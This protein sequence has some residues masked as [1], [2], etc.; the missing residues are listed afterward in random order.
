MAAPDRR[1]RAAAALA[2]AA[3]LSGCAHHELGRSA[4]LGGAS[5]KALVRLDDGGE[6]WV[7]REEPLARRR[8]PS[9]PLRHDSSRLAELGFEESG[10]GAAL[11]PGDEVVFARRVRREAGV[12]RKAA[13]GAYYV[14]ALPL[15]VALTVATLGTTALL[16]PDWDPPRWI[17]DDVR[18]FRGTVVEVREAPPAVEAAA[19]APAKLRCSDAAAWYR[20]GDRFY[21]PVTAPAL[22]RADVWAPPGG[23]RREAGG[24]PLA[25][26]AQ[27]EDSALRGGERT[28]LRGTARVTP[29]G[30]DARAVLTGEARA[31]VEEQE[32]VLLEG[33]EKDAPLLALD[34]EA[35]RVGLDVGEA[36]RWRLAYATAPATVV[37]ELVLAAAPEHLRAIEAS[38]PAGWTRE[39]GAD[40]RC[41]VY[42][43][44]LAPDAGLA[45]RG[46][47]ELRGVA[48]LD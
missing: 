44:R 15:T 7:S 43:W 47:V 37:D 42:V 6:A 45:A 27:R 3:L 34:V 14:T 17:E 11:A 5:G 10:P 24:D 4:A 35:S 32:R 23:R 33:G 48:A 29:F 18:A 22:V 41:P 25:T 21:G 30:E 12:G 46:A 13:W 31:L 26:L 19:P 9:G 40:A 20:I 2:A 16:I 36:I 8:D 38:G 28:A 39:A 1:L